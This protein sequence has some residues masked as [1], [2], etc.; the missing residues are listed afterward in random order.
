MTIAITGRSV[1]RQSE[2]LTETAIELIVKL[3]RELNE[4]RKELLGARKNRIKEIASGKELHF[5][6]ETKSIR[7]D[8]SWKVAPLAP[9]LLDRRV[10]IT[11]PT[12]RKM[13]INALNSGAKVWLADQEDST[14]PNW[15]NVI[16]GQI[17][18]KDA[19][20]GDIEF[21][22]EAGKKYQLRSDAP[23]ATIVM[24]PRGLHLPEKHILIDGE[25]TSV[26]L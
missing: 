25:V 15:E 18:L 13:T 14:T 1:A 9:G 4:R 6:E 22:N 24:R 23:L 21:V 26:R 8:L 11:G 10:E 12:E 5:L 3:H 7:E 19:I 20:N 16:Q 17:N 2:V